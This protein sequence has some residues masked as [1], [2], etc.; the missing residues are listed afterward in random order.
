MAHR[1]LSVGRKASN[2][3]CGHV[4]ELLANQLAP[5]SSASQAPGYVDIELVS[6]FLLFL[7]RLLDCNFVSLD[8]EDQGVL[9]NRWDFL[10]GEDAICK[11]KVRSE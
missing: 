4:L 6:W 5:I 3:V 10:L 7:S 11:K 2:R 1:S 9:L 8:G